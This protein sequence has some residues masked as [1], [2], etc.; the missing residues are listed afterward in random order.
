VHT[1]GEGVLLGTVRDLVLQVCREEGIP[2]SDIPP[3]IHDIPSWEGCMITSTS[4]LCLP[5]DRLF[6]N[7]PGMSPSTHTFEQGGLAA[8]IDAL[9]IDAVE[10]SSELVFAV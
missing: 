5:V 4:R 7:I 9:V 10:K 6:V 8:R 2:V 3:R 1:A